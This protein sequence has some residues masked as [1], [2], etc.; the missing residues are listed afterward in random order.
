M[1]SCPLL[2]VLFVACRM[3]ALQI[4]Q[5]EGIP[6]QWAHN[7]MFTAVF[8]C[9]V[10]PI[11]CLMVPL[12]GRFA[13]TVD[14]D[15]NVTWDST[16]MVGAYAVTVVKYV[17][18]MSSSRGSRRCLWGPMEVLMHPQVRSSFEASC[19]RALYPRSWR[20]TRSRSHA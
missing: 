6:Q 7:C 9:Y 3:R 13:T 18:M 4:T 10:Q 5:Q 8:A 20:C 16:P 12:F 2:C 19:A 17:A 1:G 11:C 14:A 15:G